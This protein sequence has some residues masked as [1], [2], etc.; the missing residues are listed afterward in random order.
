MNRYAVID[1]GTNTCNLLIT[2]ILPDYSFETLY[3]RKLPVKLGRGGIHKDIL[4]PEAIE[5]GMAAGQKHAE[6]RL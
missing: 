4:L 2:N 1:L 6:T 3:D 5:R